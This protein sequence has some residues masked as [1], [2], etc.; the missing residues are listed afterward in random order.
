MAAYKVPRSARCFDE[1]L[2]PLGWRCTGY[3]GGNHL[4]WTHPRCVRPLITSLSPSDGNAG[5]QA[6]RHARRLLTTQ[7]DGRHGE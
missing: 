6:A 3:T 7:G 1:A 4:K 5:K 2:S